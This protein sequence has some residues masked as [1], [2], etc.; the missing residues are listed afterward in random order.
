MIIVEKVDKKKLKTGFTT[1][2]SATAAAIAAAQSIIE[3]KVVDVVEVKLPKGKFIKIPIHLCNF[4]K[5]SAHCSVIKDGGDDPESV[6]VTTILAVRV[7]RSAR[8][9]RRSRRPPAP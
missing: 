7:R 3:Q 4:E 6:D 8:G 1:G 5:E 9:L 2:T